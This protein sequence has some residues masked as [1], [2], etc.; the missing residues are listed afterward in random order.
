MDLQLTGKTVLVTGGSKGIGLGVAQAFAAEGCGLHLVSRSP[1]NLDA[2]KAAIH[3]SH[4][5]AVTLH[6]HDLSD[7]AAVTALAESCPE[8][9][10]LVNN[11]GAI[12]GGDLD[13]VDEASW[14][15]AWDLKVFGYLNMTR[16]YYGAMRRRGR[17]VILNVI[18][19]AGEKPD[20]GYVAGSAGNA[21]LM[22]FTRAI[23]GVSLDHGVR[24][25]GVNPGPVETERI[26]R[27][28]QAKAESEFGD[29]GRWRDYLKVLPKGR[30]ASVPEI[31]EVVVFLASERAAYMS[32]TI[33]TIDG[34]AAARSAAA[35]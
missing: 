29:A 18:G 1:D 32:G 7:S 12:P 17:G 5:V 21:A 19:L 28:F 26:V 3:E 30:P 20:H 6:A 10:I 24:V 35:K 27:L 23:G 25:L 14:R 22:A 9:D 31:A 11:A 34:G 16:V 13:T 4:D 8:V 33:V 15:Q 2:A